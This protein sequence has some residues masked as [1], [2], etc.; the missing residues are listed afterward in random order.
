[1]MR[2]L[3]VL[4]AC[5]GA[6]TDYK[7]HKIPNKL[8]VNALLAGLLLNL[9]L[10]G[11]QGLLGSALGAL[12]G[13]SFILLW[14]LGALKAGD[15]KLYIAIGALGGWKFGLNSMI[16]SILIGGIAA[17]VVMVFRKSGRKSLKNLRNYAVNLILTRK[18]HTYEGEESAYFCFGFC[19]AAGAV[20]ALVLPGVV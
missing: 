13:F 2:I 15:V 5:A 11:G 3:A 17:V 19:I 12:A 9:L 4:V 16:D 14:C 10:E 20:A 7:T 18:F 8:T 1:M 6:M